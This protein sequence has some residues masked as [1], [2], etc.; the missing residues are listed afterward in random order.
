MAETNNDDIVVVGGATV[1]A[2]LATRRGA[3]LYPGDPYDLD[4][5][6]LSDVYLDVMTSGDGVTYTYFN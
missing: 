6:D 3:P 2:A 4:I 1:V 5:D